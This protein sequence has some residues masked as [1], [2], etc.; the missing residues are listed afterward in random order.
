MAFDAQGPIEEMN[1]PGD[2]RAGAPNWHELLTRIL[3]RKLAIVGT[4]LIV[5]G[6]SVLWVTQLTP[7]YV[8]VAKIVIQHPFM[9]MVAGVHEA[10]RSLGSDYYSMQTQAE[11]LRS[12]AL[13]DR[14]VDRFGLVND[15]MFNPA[16]RPPSESLVDR[17][18]LRDLVP[19]SWLIAFRDLR[20]EPGTA[21]ESEAEPSP[22]QQGRR[23]REQ[24]I[25]NYL[26][27]LSISFEA[28]S[29]VIAVRFTAGDAETPARLA[30]AAA[31]V[32]I[33]N[34]IR[35]V[36]EHAELAAAWLQDR[37]E[38]L[39]R[40]IDGSA[41]RLEEQRLKVGSVGVGGTEALAQQVAA[42]TSLLIA[43]RAQR[44]VAEARYGQVQELLKAEDGIESAATVVDLP[45]L[46]RLRDRRAE[47]VRKIAELRTQVA[48]DDPQLVNARTQA[49]SIAREIETEVRNAVV[50]LGNAAEL[51]RLR[52]T[53]LQHEVAALREEFAAR[54]EAEIT[55]RTLETELEASRKLYDIVLARLAGTDLEDAAEIKPY[56]R[57]I[58]YAAVPGAPALPRKGLTIG[59]AL[60]ASAIL[61]ILL[62][63][64]IERLDS[65]FRNREQAEAVTGLTV[66]CTV[67]RLRS[68]RFGRT[69]PYEEVLKRPD[70]G[71][72]ES[73]RRLRTAISLSNIDRPPRTAIITS[74]VSGEGRSTTVL[75]LGRTAAKLGERC[76]IIDGDLRN[77]SLHDAFGT[78]NDVGLTDYLSRDVPI[79]DLVQIDFESGAHY[80][81]A[82]R[83]IALS[84]G[85][86][87]S[88]K[89]RGLLYGLREVYDF[90]VIDTSP[91]LT[92]S[93]TQMLLRNGDATL[94]LIR[95]EKTRRKTALAGVRKLLDADAN[96]AGLVL[97]HAPVEKRN[98]GV[99]D[100]AQSASVETAESVV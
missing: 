74:A 49:R 85:L 25:D 81:P 83:A 96:L 78:P 24:V 47:V 16:L 21:E 68:L 6:I 28:E 60:T 59:A 95:W 9:V 92:A 77:P 23:V 32:Y 17:F 3:R 40:R 98:V 61:G 15:P 50:K 94:F 34:Q 84:A 72:S 93:D 11:I 75:A 67:P 14:V 31:E 30:N 18:G 8:A 80:I 13:A 51:A 57:I 12:R 44:A 62:A 35:A 37:A 29:R 52:E 55:L 99:R 45:M 43:V 86:L 7:R 88:E 38:A 90:V 66:L 10:A 46:P 82:G 87:A 39:K 58:S 91:I 22:V 73:I 79:E 65:G 36:S 53:S 41:R 1:G 27:R 33:D 4:V 42:L 100:P 5:T 56:A 71:F 97:T 76:M 89:M 26:S 64:L 54:T 69:L 48:A 2:D 20:G 70:S 19:A 63:L